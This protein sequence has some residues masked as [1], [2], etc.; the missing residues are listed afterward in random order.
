MP[1]KFFSFRKCFTVMA[2]L[3]LIRYI[4]HMQILWEIQKMEKVITEARNHL[5]CC[6]NVFRDLKLFVIKLIYK[7]EEISCTNR[8]TAK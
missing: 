7:S 6:G 2:I 8:R 4:S 5:F 3:I 1:S